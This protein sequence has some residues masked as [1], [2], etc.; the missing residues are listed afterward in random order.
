MVRRDDDERAVVEPHV[1]KAIE[2][3]A[4]EPVRVLELE[5]EALLGLKGDPI[6]L[7]PLFEAAQ[8]GIGSNDVRVALAG[9]QVPPRLVREQHVQVMEDGAV[10]RLNLLHE[11]LDLPAPADRAALAR[12]R[13]ADPLSIGNGHVAEDRGDRGEDGPEPAFVG[14]LRDP[15]AEAVRAEVGPRLRDVHL[16]ARP[17]QREDRPRMV[18]RRPEAV[19][20]G[21]DARGERR[22]GELRVAARRRAVPVPGRV[23]GQR[24]EVREP[25]GV[26]APPSV[27]QR[28]AGQ[29]VE[30]DHDDRRSRVRLLRELHLVLAAED[31]AGDRREQKDVD[32][33]DRGR[34]ASADTTERAPSFRA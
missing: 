10:R 27:H 16:I 2:Q 20:R 7:G 6:V 11:R 5:E 21:V 30:D 13:N 32:K 14:A 33:D 34:G 22:H 31:Q 24:R 29:L 9:R 8:L 23:I 4:E 25:L 19:E 12:A 26:D 18:G 3:V 28:M 1:A 17:E 15:I